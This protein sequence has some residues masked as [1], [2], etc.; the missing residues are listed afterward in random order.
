VIASLGRRF[1]RLATRL[2]VR[3]PRTWRLVRGL[4]RAQFDSLAPVWDR[5]RDPHAFAALEL[6]LVAIDGDVRSALDVGTGTGEAAFAVVRRFPTAEVLGID[7]SPRMIAEAS[8]KRGDE[9]RVAFEVGDA[10]RVERPDSSF[11]LVTAANMIPFFDEVARLVA[12]GGYFVA[13]FSAGSETPIY[14]PLEQLRAEFA[15]RGF[16]EFAEFSAG[17]GSAFVARKR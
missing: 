7:L 1:A 10:S 12:P 8:R 13:S 17:R 9:A 15:R 2:V 6:A 5:E 3:W 11:D 14:V 4:M 16:S